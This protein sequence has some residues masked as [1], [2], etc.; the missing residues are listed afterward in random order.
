MRADRGDVVT[1]PDCWC[2]SVDP[3]ALSVAEIGWER[4]SRL[5]F[6]ELGPCP[7]WHTPTGRVL[8]RGEYVTRAEAR[9]IAEAHRAVDAANRASAERL[10][11]ERV[12]S[13]P[14]RV[15]VRD[16]TIA[17][18]R[19]LANAARV[20]KR[21]TLRTDDVLAALDDGGAS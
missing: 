21:K 12:E 6:H 17:R 1:A 16:A 8:A 13:D 3:T 9:E 5:P 19:D 7:P 15:R 14:Q 20:A 10:L 11:A 4:V 2:A 18:V